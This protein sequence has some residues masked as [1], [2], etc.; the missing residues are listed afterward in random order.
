MKSTRSEIGDPTSSTKR[1][2]RSSTTS[3][4]DKCRQK[5]S[6][7]SFEQGK[8]IRS[9]NFNMIYIVLCSGKM[10]CSECILRHDICTGD[11]TPRVTPQATP[12]PLQEELEEIERLKSTIVFLIRRVS[13][14]EGKSTATILTEIRDAISPP[15]ASSSSTSPPPPLIRSNALGLVADRSS[16][17]PSE[18]SRE[19]KYRLVMRDYQLEMGRM[20]GLAGEGKDNI[21]M[22]VA[23]GFW[24][25]ALEKFGLRADEVPT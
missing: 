22:E 1:P 24:E 16:S 4:C 21:S 11:I 10:P 13:D 5:R 7:F 25:N 20:Y 14:L 3:T 15:S 9:A 2:K 19:E 17:L 6:R 8:F 23:M 12:D 18:L